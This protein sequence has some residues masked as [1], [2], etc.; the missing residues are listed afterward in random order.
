MEKY[1]RSDAG[2]AA[3]A[4]FCWPISPVQ[5]FFQRKLGR[6][7]ESLTVPERTSEPAIG[8][9]NSS[10]PKN[11]HDCCEGPQNTQTTPKGKTR[12]QHSCFI[13]RMLRA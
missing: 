13:P 11:Q 2:Q 5:T 10:R 12:R 7:P 1:S 9:D 3:P 4:R 6:T 8:G